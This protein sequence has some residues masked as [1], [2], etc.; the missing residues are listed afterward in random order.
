LETAKIVSV[1]TKRKISVPCFFFFLRWLSK[2]E[3]YSS[4]REIELTNSPNSFGLKAGYGFKFAAYLFYVSG[5]ATPLP[6]KI[7]LALL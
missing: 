7:P 3:K 2:K 6:F 4:F 5:T 1:R